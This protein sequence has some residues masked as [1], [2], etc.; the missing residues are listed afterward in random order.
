MVAPSSFTCASLVATQ[1]YVIALNRFSGRLE[2]V[3]CSWSQPKLVAGGS[4]P[5]VQPTDADATRLR[6]SATNP[7]IS[8]SSKADPL[9]DAK[10][11]IDDDDDDADSAED[12][13][14]KGWDSDKRKLLE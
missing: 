3:N 6:R 5:S 8:K 14:V 12:A 13:Y 2:F 11:V 7:E 10:F 4:T 9:N 1:F